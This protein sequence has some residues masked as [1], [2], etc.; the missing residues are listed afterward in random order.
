MMIGVLMIFLIGG[1]CAADNTPHDA[2]VSS[3]CLNTSCAAS[4][5]ENELHSSVQESNREDI[6]V[7]YSFF[8]DS[9]NNSSGSLDA[10][11]K[12]NADTLSSYDGKY[13]LFRGDCWSINNNFESSAAVTSETFKDLTVTGTFRTQSDMVGLYWNSKDIITH[14]YISYGSRYDYSGVKLE[15]DY[16]MTGCTDFSNPSISIS[17]VKN[18]GETYYLTMNRFIKKNHVTIDFNKLTLLA[19]NSYFDKDGREQ[20]VKKQTKLDVTDIKSIMLVLVP[21]G[22][23]PAS[24]YTIMKNANFTCRI[25]NINVVNGAICIEQPKLDPHQYRLCEGYD[26]IYNMNPYRISNEMRKLGYVGWVNL[27]LGASHYYEK[28]GDVGDII[29]DNAFTNNRTEKMTLDKDV[30]LNSAFRAWLDCYSRKLKMNDVE[31][32]VISVSM[33]N[34]QTPQ[35]WRQMDSNDNF[36]VTGWNPSTFLISPCNDDA[37]EYMQRV[38]AE[39]LDITVRNGFKPVLQM[40]EVWWW[41]NENDMPNQ[42]PCFYDNAT[43]TKYLAEHGVPL[44]EY[45]NVST[46][47]YDRN[48]M[49]WLN[50][51]LV[52]YSDSLSKVVK[53][54]RYSDGLY[55]ALFYLPSVIDEDRVPSMM[56]DVNYLPDAYSPYKLDVLQIEDYD[57]VINQS[58]HHREAY[59]VG[60]ELGFN[61]SGLHYFGGF[62]LYPE[63]AARY[64]PLIEKALED[65]IAHNF[66]EVYVW[67]GTQ[68]RR[69]SKILGYD[70]YAILRNLE[71]TGNPGIVSPV[72]TSPDYVSVGE[73]FTIEIQTN[74]WI[75]GNF[76]VYEYNNTERG[77]LLGTGKIT[78]GHSSLSLS[79]SIAGMNR[80]YLEF[81]YIGGGYHMLHDVLIIENSKNVTVEVSRQIEPGFVANISLEAPSNSHGTIYILV[82]GK[83]SKSFSVTGG[84]F[85]ATVQGLSS[86]SHTVLVRYNDGTNLYHKTFTVNVG[87]R[88]VIESGDLTADY[89]SPSLLSLNLKDSKGNALKAKE[90]SVN[91]NG[92]NYVI[93][94]DNNGHATLPIDLLPG[95]YTAEIAYAGD[96]NYLSSSACVN[97]FI[98]KISTSLTANDIRFDYGDS[99]NLIV[100]LKDAKNNALEGKRVSVILN[101]KTHTLTTDKQGR[102]TLPVDLIPGKYVANIQF[103]EDNIYLGSSVSSNVVVNKLATALTANDINMVYGDS[104]SLVVALKDAK[105]NDLAGKVISIKLNGKDYSVKT[106]NN[107]KATLSVDLVPGKYMAKI[108]FSEDSIYLSSSVSSDIVVNKVATVLSVNDIN[109][110]YGD[111]ASL[112]VALKDRNNAVLKGKNIFINLNGKDIT[113]K[114]GNDG[115]ATLPI[116]LLPG[117]YVAKIKFSEDSIYLSSSVSSNV[118]VNKLA[119]ALSA[120]DINI[121]YGDS[122]NLI[123]VLKDAKSNALVGKD[124][125]INL[126]GKDF[127]VK[128]GNDGKA[129]LP[130]D[131]I[132]GKYAAMIQFKED[133]IYLSSSVNL[134]VVVNKLATAL[135]VNDINMVYGDSANLII[136]LKDKNNAVL[137]GK[138]ISI[139]LNGKD[140]IVKTGNDGKATL[141]VDLIPGKY[142]AK[143]KFNEDNIYLAS[144]VS[145]NI[146]VNKVATALTAGDINIT[147]GDSANLI[148]TLNDRNN[149]VLKGKDISVNLN[150]KEYVVKTGNDGKATLPI[151]LLPGKYVAKIKFNE[152]NIY[153]ASYMSSNV[154]VNKLA[155]ALTANDINILYGDSANLIIALKDAKSN[156]LVGKDISVNLNGKDYVVKTGNDGKAALPIDLVPGKY[157]A[158]IEFKGDNIY[159]A[160]YVNSNM[161]VNKVST[162]LT[163]NDI[164][165]VYGDSA[166]LCITLKDR[167]NAVLKG[168]DISVNLNGKDYSV[169][170]GNDG[171]ATLPVDL[172]PG[173][174]M[175]KIQF[176]EDSIYL[177]SSVSSNIIVNKVTTALTVNDINMVYGDSANII[178]VL[179]DA[180]SNA[181]V[182]KDISVNLN[183]KDFTVKTGNDGKA[184]LPIDLLPGKYVAKIKFNEDNIYLGSSVNSNIVV[185]KV[186]TSLTVNDINIVYGDSA[187]LIIALKDAKSNALVGKDISVNLNGKDFTVKTGNDGQA[188][189]PIDLVPGKYTAKIKFNEDSIY[190]DSS[191]SSNIVV[192]KLA[193]ALTAGDINITYGDSAN[194]IITLKDTKGNALSG[195]VILININDKDCFT[196]TDNNGEAAL[197]ID[198]LPGKYAS[199]IEFGEDEIYLPS[200]AGAEISVDKVDTALSANNV[201]MVYDDSKNLVVTLT[202]SKGNA[203][204]GKSVTIRLSDGVY[205]KK[206]NAKGQVVLSVDEPAGKYN[207]KISFTGDDIYKSSG[208]TS[209]VTVSKAASKITASAKV[210]KVKSKSKKLTVILKNKNRVMKNVIVK[211]TVNKKTYKVKTNS[212]GVAVFAIKLTKK[213][214]YDAVYKFEG[215]SNFK[216]STKT[217]K[218]SII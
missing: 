19:G 170:T 203:L 91:L 111:S 36:A 195:K 174:Y 64:W 116:N 83:V 50:Q 199:K 119:T 30:P 89:Y 136:S 75:G 10:I 128:T 178:I 210:F 187:N 6:G 167:N 186:S 4:F 146:I 51:Q 90:I 216:S 88:T 2:I 145:S 39:C 70:E 42:S 173:K 120:N 69:D 24:T 154:V 204:L 21:E 211:L 22:Y 131:L 38:S 71:M 218:I 25:S 16:E 95:N 162:A 160:T 106:D 184:A 201:N 100:T 205:T 37:V 198:L 55:I 97:I 108:K 215:N 5:D 53:S 137:K 135:S 35:S 52:K 109:M 127:T 94:T 57:W 142:T 8:D 168:K 156:A 132:P 60:K 194:L 138:N 183:G 102:A 58:I 208:H 189:L 125:S 164:N 49:K 143:I 202:D 12:P 29:A 73:N 18:S 209:R 197:P 87:I 207:A 74:Q 152:D 1:V 77:N 63:D 147:Y 92:I 163:V 214:K 85:R 26:D 27:Y 141:P 185:N 79:S 40:G 159:L 11:S 32:L 56:I 112:V 181:L 68:V 191:V 103:S 158:K 54:D 155:T 192:N 196:T 157:T 129:T 148:I 72:I 118:V 76:K 126:N 149:A 200:F 176:K 3:N 105:S 121:V 117:K 139:N 172:I 177:G 28:Y 151:D 212:K 61:E 41:W 43:R 46:K 48:A 169:K 62:V 44:P 65:A 166:N 104:A 123:I 9:E 115:K 134:N 101:G 13:Y 190:L 144:S 133:N 179:K 84:K 206:T 20:T 15:F 193:T 188:T 34:I 78:N 161:V 98:K 66:K 33:E 14:P 7:Q 175:A 45:E 23:V 67:A 213:G 124:I 171:K 130:V 180:K 140:F 82:D 93:T 153:L 165:I 86:G 96:S 114:T 110:V 182:G 107:G 81:D 31:N 47:E 122:A 80:F 99:T 217:V 113:V 17:I 150:G 59:A